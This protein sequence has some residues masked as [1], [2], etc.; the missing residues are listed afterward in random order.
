MKLLS[1]NADG[2][3]KTTKVK[4]YM[5]RIVAIDA[6]MQLYQFMSMVRSQQHGGPAQLLADENG[7]VTSHILGFFHRTIRLMEKGLKPVY[8][9]DGKPPEM[10][11]NELKKRKAEKAKAQS[12]LKELE[13]KLKEGEGTNESRLCFECLIDNST[14]EETK[15]F[16]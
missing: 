9:F 4:N 16:Q 15:Q 12:E 2:C 1:E 5:G 7:E 8:V 11:S 13:A 10:K 3:Y 14:Q 6:S